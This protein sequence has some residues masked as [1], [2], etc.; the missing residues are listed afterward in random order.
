M[1]GEPPMKARE[2]LRFCTLIFLEPPGGSPVVC[3]VLRWLAV[4][5]GAMRVR[6]AHRFT[7]VRPPETPQRI[8][9]LDGRLRSRYGFGEMLVARCRRAGT[10]RK[11][12]IS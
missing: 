3:R 2:K 8:E 1:A 9:N 4:A 6:V 5:G 12:C 10:G 7:S 11:R